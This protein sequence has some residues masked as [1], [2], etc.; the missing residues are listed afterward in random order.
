MTEHDSTLVPVVGPDGDSM[1]A[2]LDAN[3][4]RPFVA[5]REYAKSGLR[6]GLAP[7]AKAWMDLLRESRY[8]HMPVL[9]E[10]LAAILLRLKERDLVGRSD[11]EAISKRRGRASDPGEFVDGAFS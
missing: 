11:L 9:D 5:I 1:G 2:L 6:R 3:R 4:G 7:P 10:D 8:H